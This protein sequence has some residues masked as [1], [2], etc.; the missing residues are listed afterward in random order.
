MLQSSADGS[1][2][3]WS[4]A[5][6]RLPLLGP[7]SAKVVGVTVGKDGALIWERGASDDLVRAFPSPLVHAVDTLNA[8]D[9]WHVS[10]DESQGVLERCANVL[11]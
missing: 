2:L 9:V 1:A 11:A 6:R 4:T 5:A 8:G 3:S 10:R 7:P